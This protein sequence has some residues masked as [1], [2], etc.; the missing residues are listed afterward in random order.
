MA[1]NTLKNA[2]VWGIIL[3]G[4]FFRLQEY[5]ANHPLWL[6]EAATAYKLISLSMGEMIQR[7]GSDF[8]KMHAYPAGFLWA[9][10]ALV[11]FLGPHEMVLRLLP[12][13]SALASLW[14]FARV[15]QKFF[16]YP[17]DVLALA[18]FSFAPMPIQYANQ[19]KPFSLD[20]MVALGFLLLFLNIEKVF[21][22]WRRL[23]ALTLVGVAGIYFSFIG[24][25]VL[26]SWG[27]L[28][29]IFYLRS[30]EGRKAR[31]LALMLSFWALAFISYFK[32]SL[33]YFLQD[34]GLLRYWHGSFAPLQ[35]G[36]ME[37]AGWIAAQT[38]GFFR[39][40]LGLPAGLG[41]FFIIVGLA[42]AVSKKERMTLFLAAPVVLMFFLSAMRLY[43]FESRMLLFL[44]PLTLCLLV[45]GA[46]Q[47][48]QFQSP[49]VR[50]L[51][52]AVTAVLLLFYPLRS[53][54]GYISHQ[55]SKEDIRSVMA[56]LKGQK[57]P[58]DSL[59]INDSAQYGYVY[60]HCYFGWKEPEARLIK[61][62][63]EVFHDA[64]G[65]YIY[66]WPMSVSFDERGCYATSASTEDFTKHYLSGR[67]VFGENKR[68]WLVYS[69]PRLRLPEFIPAYLDR[70]G[71][72][73]PSTKA[74][75]AAA[76]V[77]DLGP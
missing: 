10:K 64:R 16:I 46:F 74:R 34:E 39:E 50:P 71:K 27:G 66:L 8:G 14:L 43:P 28:S 56:V 21:F 41:V 26:M 53:A 22:S 38:E 1:K 5:F 70:E 62:S 15:T 33:R 68:T 63:D 51:L 2:S 76:L 23:L 77:Y 36:L 17:W 45:Q 44:M 4:V 37:N 67:G 49:A 18:L 73:G 13:A 42:T 61:F 19:L 7:G 75:N 24:I 32:L 31:W 20:C 30:G 6:D 12:L 29:F 69:H 52:A 58:Q 72:A 54:L 47:F 57:Q 35:N 65:P 40:G 55:Q 3:L 9:Q 48:W 60:Y 59:Y 11:S 25:V